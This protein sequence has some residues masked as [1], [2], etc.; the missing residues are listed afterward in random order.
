[1]LCCT[2]E[3]EEYRKSPH[4]QQG[5]R[6]SDPCPAIHTGVIYIGNLSSRRR[7]R[8]EHATGPGLG[9]SV[10]DLKDTK[11]RGALIAS[12][13]KVGAELDRVERIQV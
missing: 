10:K 7:R 5:N 11:R 3:S 12:P 13:S 2:G 9:L 6:G 4:W 8:F 1:M